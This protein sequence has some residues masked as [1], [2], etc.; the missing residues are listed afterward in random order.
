MPEPLFFRLQLGELGLSLLKVAMITAPGEQ[1]VGPGDRIARE[2]ADDQQGQGRPDSPANE[3]DIAFATHRVPT[4]I[5]KE[6]RT[7]AKSVSCPRKLGISDD[8]APP[9][10]G[11]V[12]RRARRWGH[13]LPKRCAERLLGDYSLRPARIF[14][15]FAHLLRLAKRPGR[16]PEEL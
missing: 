10:Q 5:T 9:P 3:S 1:P 8:I 7:Q 14:S 4:R 12:A 2:I 11:E 6:S 15:T 13:S 16:H